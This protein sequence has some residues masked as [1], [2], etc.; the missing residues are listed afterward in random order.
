MTISTPAKLIT[1]EVL[2]PRLGEQLVEMG[3]LD[4]EQLKLA[5]GYQRQCVQKGRQL[6]IG[7]AIMELGFLDRPTLD[8]AVTEQIFRLRSALEDVNQNLELRVQQRTLELEE[9][10]RRLSESNKLKANFVANISHE[11][12]TPLTHIRG[13]L[14]LLN[15]GSFG[16]MDPEQKQAIDLSLQASLHLQ[17]L[18]DDLILF[19]Q[20]SRGQMN[21]AIAPLDLD[22]LARSMLL[23]YK[24]RA[25]EH[26]LSLELKVDPNLPNVQADEEKLTWVIAHLLGNAI[27]FSS[28]GG[29]VSLTMHQNPASKNTV[30]I[31]INDTGIGISPEH[32]KEIFEPFHQLD[33]STTRRYGGTGLGLNL[34]LQ[35][36]EAHGST[37]SVKSELNKGTRVSFPLSTTK[38]E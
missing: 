5:L 26:Q 3:L 17:A 24:R 11:L 6:L 25:A 18:I 31:S 34:V 29:K 22:K 32:I 28:P 4:A 35:I 7:Q 9:A 38:A 36:I 10:L 19:S 14:D 1:P 27:K 16:E 21:L 37:V 33:G 12:R 15:S 23:R 30:T 8:Q 2:I 20:A 13:Y